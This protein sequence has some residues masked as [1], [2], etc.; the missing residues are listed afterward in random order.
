MKQADEAGAAVLEKRPPG[1]KPPTE[2][3]VEISDL[4]ETNEALSDEVAEWKKRFEIAQTFLEL[5]RKHGREAGMT[6][7]KTKKSGGPS[8]RRRRRANQGKKKTS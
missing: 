7:K 2:H 5:E 1:R 8:A 4:R 3:E 6:P